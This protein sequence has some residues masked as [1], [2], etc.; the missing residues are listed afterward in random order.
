MQVQLHSHGQSKCI[1]E[2][3][4]QKT[5]ILACA[6]LVLFRMYIPFCKMH[7]HALTPVYVGFQS[8][9]PIALHVCH[10]PLRAIH[11]MQYA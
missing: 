10:V 3:A 11:A 4:S 6:H 2:V 7:L 5:N 8:V 9:K 1:L